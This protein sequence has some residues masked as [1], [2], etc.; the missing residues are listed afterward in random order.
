MAVPQGL[1]YSVITG[2][3]PINGLYASLI[4][5]IVFA[6]LGTSR[7]TAVG[8]FGEDELMSMTDRMISPDIHHGI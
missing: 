6:F 7:E 1:A 8:P 2:L 4:P 3:P 5:L